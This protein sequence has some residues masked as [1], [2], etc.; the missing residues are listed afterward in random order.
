VAVALYAYQ[1]MTNILAPSSES[2]ISYN[3]YS[4]ASMLD[5]SFIFYIPVYDNM[6]NTVSPHP[7]SE[8]TEST[9]TGT[10]IIYLDDGKVN[11]TDYFNV[12]SGAGDAFNVIAQIVEVSEGAENRKKFTRTQVGTSGWDKVKL[13]DGTEGYVYQGYVHNYNYT[14]VSS[15]TLDKTTST[16]KASGTINLSANILPANSYIKNITW[17]SSNTSVATVN[18]S[19]KVTAVA[20]GTANIVAKTLDGNK[21]ATCIVT[22]EKTLASSISMTYSEYP[23]VVGKYLQFT[24]V[25]APATATDKGYKI[26]IADET[27][28]KIENNKIKG[29]KEGNT[30]VTLTTKDGSSKSCTF[31]LKVKET[32]ATVN[33]LTVD[34][35]NVITKVSLGTVSS[36]IKNNIT[37]SY[38]KKI[39]DLNGAEL[40]E[41]DKVGTGSKVQ[42]INNGSVL[43]EYTVVIYGDVN[44]DAKASSS[45]Y[46]L[47]KNYIMNN[48]TTLNSIQEIGADYNN[49]GK[50]SSSDYVLIKN[51]IMK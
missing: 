5:S 10:D 24:P 22:V 44:G 18:S 50:V 23:L 45:D 6:P 4:K 51:Y 21:A 42:I 31:T 28:A 34:D 33:N 39:L 25:V 13:G 3:A 8:I 17:S 49:D 14:H 9:I 41:T 36:S 11:G 40:K 37:T 15:I 26:A 32:V 12:R 29:L 20:V 7:D 30:T 47:I 48:K 38:T 16:L 35:N 19:G 43:E 27:I 46:V 1:Y 2:I